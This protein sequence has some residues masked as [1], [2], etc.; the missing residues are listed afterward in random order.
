MPVIEGVYPKG[1]V[2]LLAKQQE[3][4]YSVNVGPKG[5]CAALER[6]YPIGREVAE[7]VLRRLCQGG[8]VNGIRFGGILEML[9]QDSFHPLPPLRGQVYI[10]LASRW[11]LFESR[12]SQFP[13][14]ENELPELTVEQE[15]HLL[16]TIRERTIERVELGHAKPHLILTLDTGA[17]FFLCGNNDSYESWDVGVAMGDRSEQWHVIALPGGEVGIWAPKP[18]L[19]ALGSHR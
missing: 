10:N 3:A 2:L 13:E 18:F 9:V 15:L 16:C 5:A 14:H 17:I 8:S 12:P 7:A 19:E 6:T 1:L 11:T 4:Q